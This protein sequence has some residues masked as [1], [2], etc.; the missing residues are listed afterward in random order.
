MSLVALVVAKGALQ[1]SN[2]VASRAPRIVRRLRDCVVKPVLR[3]VLL[4]TRSFCDS[5][6]PSCKRYLSISLYAHSRSSAIRS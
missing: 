2:G 6:A 5:K 4:A 1:P 3:R